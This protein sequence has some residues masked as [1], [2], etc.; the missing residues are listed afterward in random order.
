VRYTT[1]DVKTLFSVVPATEFSKTDIEELAESIL[2]HGG[3]ARPIILKQIHLESLEVVAG[4]LS[5]HA[6]VRAR[7]MD[8]RKA[9]MINAFVVKDDEIESIKA[10]LAIYN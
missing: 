1:A 2:Q 7:E 3:L 4:H 5:Y 9:E 6:A 8:P 10:Q